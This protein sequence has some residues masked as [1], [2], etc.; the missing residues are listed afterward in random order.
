MM[1]CLLLQKCPVNFCKIIKLSNRKK[2]VFTTPLM[3]TLV[4][5]NI[6]DVS[7]AFPLSRK[8]RVSAYL[9]TCWKHGSRMQGLN[10]S[11]QCQN[12]SRKAVPVRRSVL[13]AFRVL[14]LL[15][16]LNKSTSC[17]VFPPEL[18]MRTSQGTQRAH[19]DYS[20]LLLPVASFLFPLTKVVAVFFPIGWWLTNIHWIPKLIL[21]LLLTCNYFHIIIQ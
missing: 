10:L 6:L 17:L 15:C 1:V 21:F 16:S 12:R 2:V 19:S 3:P 20:L 7:V 9:W 18:P 11:P 13:T 8:G 14:E 4:L 5:K